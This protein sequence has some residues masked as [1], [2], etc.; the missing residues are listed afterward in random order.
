[1]E[2]VTMPI[3]SVNN[4]IQEFPMKTFFALLVSIACFSNAMAD[5]K[6]I[7]LSD[8]CYQD[9]KA[10]AAKYAGT[11]YNQMRAKTP[12]YAEYYGNG[13]RTIVPVF[14]SSPELD[15][16]ARVNVP[17]RVLRNKDCDVGTPYGL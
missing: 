6:I 14:I 2:I 11:K 9:A 15:Y 3:S 10:A 5:E 13:N 1:M 16:P 17:V 12:Y 7:Q 4:L 8:R